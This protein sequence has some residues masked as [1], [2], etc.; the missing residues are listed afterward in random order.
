MESKTKRGIE[1]RYAVS[2]LAIF[3]FFAIANCWDYGKRLVNA[4][5]RMR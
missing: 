3:T 2:L 4:V 5:A 1:F